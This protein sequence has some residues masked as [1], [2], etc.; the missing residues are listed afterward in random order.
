MTD[1]RWA[2][3]T[4]IEPSNGQTVEKI[5]RHKE[6]PECGTAAHGWSELLLNCA[7]DLEKATALGQVQRF[8]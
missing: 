7:L 3:A 8:K 4:Y 2:D 5:I 1:R 6:R